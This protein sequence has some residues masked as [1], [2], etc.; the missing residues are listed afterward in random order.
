MGLTLPRVITLIIS[1]TCAPESAGIR[2]AAF[3][4]FLVT[5]FIILGWDIV[6]YNYAKDE[7]RNNCTDKLNTLSNPTGKEDCYKAIDLVFVFVIFMIV[8]ITLI[9]LYFVTQ[10]Y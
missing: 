4:V 1:L 5:F 9:D 3:I 10:V 6:A 2:I 8:I 7:A